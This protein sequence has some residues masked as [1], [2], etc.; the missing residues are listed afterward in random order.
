MIV[1]R[2]PPEEEI[3][4]RLKE[5]GFEPTDEKTDTGTFWVHKESGK[6]LQVPHSVQGYYPDWLTSL[7][8]A[9][10][11]EI[12]SGSDDIYPPPLPGVF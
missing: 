8:W 7:F 4:G 5:L 2:V 9:K 12:S 11:H 10:A 3:H 6:H 1:S